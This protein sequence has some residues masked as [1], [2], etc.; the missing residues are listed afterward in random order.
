[1][2]SATVTYRFKGAMQPLAVTSVDTACDLWLHSDT[3][4]SLALQ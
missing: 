3:N 4:A 2:H 1:M